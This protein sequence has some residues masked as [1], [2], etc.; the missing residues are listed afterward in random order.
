LFGN[1]GIGVEKIEIAEPVWR[2]ALV[3]ALCN[4]E[5]TGNCNAFDADKYIKHYS[6]MH[7]N[8][9]LRKVRGRD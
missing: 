5:Y 7:G 8:H 3:H 4:M 2:R 1:G 9:K 6:G